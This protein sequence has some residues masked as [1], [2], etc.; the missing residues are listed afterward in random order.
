MAALHHLAKL[1]KAEASVLI[2]VGIADGLV[3]DLL[4][5]LGLEMIAGHHA[6]HDEQLSIGNISIPVQVI[7]IKGN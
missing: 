7:H 2:G 5:L 6:Q 4:Q 1:V 3:D